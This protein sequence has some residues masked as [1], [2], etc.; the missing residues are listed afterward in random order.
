M[1]GLITA[2][3]GWV[4]RTPGESE[5]WAAIMAET[6]HDGDARTYSVLLVDD[7]ASV[8]NILTKLLTKS[9][10]LRVV[11]TAGDGAEGIAAAGR[12]R[13]DVVLM[14]VQMPGVGGVEALPGLLAASPTSRVIMLAGPG[15]G[16]FPGR[17]AVLGGASAYI[18]KGTP[19]AEIVSTILEVVGRTQT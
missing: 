1:L 7:N 15:G 17:G 3:G 9:G 12:L 18:A 14:D 10:R 2:R 4:G 8:R 16:V 11:G 13:P 19:S 5:D 6:E